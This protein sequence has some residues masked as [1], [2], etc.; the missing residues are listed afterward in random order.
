MRP[1]QCTATESPL[2]TTPA[3][4]TNFTTS[5]YGDKKV[6]LTE[7]D[8]ESIG[9]QVQSFS[10][11]LHHVHLL[12]LLVIVTVDAGVGQ[13]LQTARRAKLTHK[14]RVLTAAIQ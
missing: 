3:V 4:S 9:V 14:Q 12:R 10:L 11:L 8:L 7:K 1:D 5:G 6:E 13:H 2:R